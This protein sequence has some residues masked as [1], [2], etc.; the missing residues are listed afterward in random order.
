MH[1]L[2]YSAITVAALILVVVAYGQSVGRADK[3]PLASSPTGVPQK[4]ITKSANLAGTGAVHPDMPY[5]T[6]GAISALGESPQGKAEEH[7]AYAASDAFRKQAQT[8]Y[9][10]GDMAG[11]EAACLDALASPPIVQGRTQHVPF[12]A[13]LLGQIYLKDGQYEKAI[14]WLKNAKLTTTTVGGGLDLD[15]ALAY[16]RQGD[17][18][19]ASRFYGN[20]SVLRYLSDGEEVLP[21]DL[22][23]TDSPKALEASIL[24]ARGL[25]AHFEARDDEALVDFQAAHSLAPDNPLVAYHCA[26]IL[27]EKRRF[28]EATPLY[29]RAAMGR[30][31]ISKEANR[32]LI[33]IRAPAGPI[34]QVK[35]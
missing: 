28:V 2:K 16:A 19:N 23:G 20:Q 9:E 13:H 3:K 29:E 11:A 21:Q 7:A 35:Q 1:I 12:V 17:Y 26:R 6:S 14:H 34:K 33:G 15:L 10:S 4:A 27:S 5:H 32:R 22:P 18:K 24:L 31:F 30:G 25:D 8:L